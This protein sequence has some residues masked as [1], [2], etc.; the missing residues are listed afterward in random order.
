[1]VVTRAVGACARACARACVRALAGTGR[2]A[3]SSTMP[4]PALAQ[5]R[6]MGRLRGYVRSVPLTTWTMC[7]VFFIV[8]VLSWLLGVQEPVAEAL[9]L[10]GEGVLSKL[11]RE[12]RSGVS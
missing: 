2:A 12:Y 9:C 7:V 4:L 5:S 6:G 11:Q 1:M 8:H 3:A 10:S